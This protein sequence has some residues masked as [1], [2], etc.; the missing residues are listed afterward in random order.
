MFLGAG[1]GEVGVAV[2]QRSTNSSKRLLKGSFFVESLPVVPFLAL[3][4]LWDSIRE[5]SHNKN[6][7]GEI[8]GRSQLKQWIQ[9][10]IEKRAGVS[11]QLNLII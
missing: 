9:I 1:W 8:F 7:H 6:G 5:R 3:Q 2:V 4:V 10:E 11:P